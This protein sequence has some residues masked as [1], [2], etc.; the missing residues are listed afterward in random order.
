MTSSMKAMEFQLH[1][2][3]V[4][5]Q[6]LLSLLDFDPGLLNS[7][8]QAKTRIRTRKYRVAVMGEFKRGKSTLLNALLGAP[9]LPADATPTT[10]AISRITYGSRERVL[11]FFRDGTSREIPFTGLSE[12][13]TKLTE[14][15]QAI[16]ASLKE[17][18]IFYPSVI[19]QN[20]ID[21]IDTPGL[22]DEEAMTRVTIDMLPLT[23]A[24]IVPIHARSPFS[25]T[26]KQFVC[27]LI[28]SSSIQNILFVVTFLD[29]LDEDDYVYED[30]MKALAGRIRREV[31][32]ELEKRETSSEE[33]QKARR[34]LDQPCIC[35][36]SASLALKAFSSGEKSLLQKSRFPEFQKLLLKILTAG[37]AEHALRAS[38][39]DIERVIAA[40]ESENEKKLQEFREKAARLQKKKRTAGDFFQNLLPQLDQLLENGLQERRDSISRLFP[41]KNQMMTRFIQGLASVRENTHPCILQVIRP[42]AD[43]MFSMAAA[44]LSSRIL[45]DLRSS[46]VRCLD[47][48]AARAGNAGIP[49]NRNDFDPPL[50]SCMEEELARAVFRFT[51]PPCPPVPDL[52]FA[53]V[54]GHMTCCVDQSVTELYWLLNDICSEIR[55]RWYPLAFRRLRDLFPEPDTIFSQEEEQLAALRITHMRNYQVLQETAASIQKKNRKLLH[56]LTEGEQIHDLQKL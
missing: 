19:C 50:L 38:I 8:E 9:I 43:A 54:T 17:A 22:N 29:Q 45:P 11:L 6:E 12:A 32:E 23:D 25:I 13:V 55:E 27:Q 51:M 49:W 5:L 44:L 3:L 46:F 14:N 47:H 24:V 56:T 16:S 53:D 31:L 48:L 41:L 40:L 36:L 52:A 2:N 21:L 4:Q 28:R 30:Y 37:Q 10:A 26:E 33:M 20:Y 34:I 18:V 35:G 7:L 42:A 15:G 39:G 1:E